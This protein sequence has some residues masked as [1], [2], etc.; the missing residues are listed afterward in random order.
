[1]FPRLIIDRE[2]LY[3]NACLIKN[4]CGKHGIEVVAVTKGYCALKGVIDVIVSAGI[5]KLADSRMLNIKRMR[6][7]GIKNHIMLIRI[8]MLSEISDV[9]RYVDS[10][11]VSEMVVLKAI[12]EECLR[13]KKEIDA[14]IMV[15]VGDLREGLMPKDVSGF[16]NE[17]K[18]LKGV[19]I[20]GIAT[21]VG[22]IGGIMPDKNNIALLIEAA[23]RAE[24]IL[25]RR[26]SVI[27]GGSTCTLKLI[28]DD[29]MPER[30]N[31][32]RIGEAILFGI[33]DVCGRD[34]PGTYKDVFTLEAEVVE[35]KRKPSKPLGEV[36]FDAFGEVPHFEDRG[37]RKRAILALGRQDVIIDSIKPRYAGMTIVGASS[38]HLILDV[39][40]YEGTIEVGDVI[41]FDV[42]YGGL[43]SAS[44]SPYVEKVIR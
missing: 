5:E 41:P 8:P 32:L 44:T 36:G 17:A 16:I 24:S 33:N 12:S 27:S 19:N 3:H 21:N 31:Q 1:M 11:L 18:D 23:D 25:G 9:V 20:A 34:I 42:T 4:L 13:Q 26:L 39:E 28:D 43:L 6:Y 22:C 29:E 40:D 37:I 15:D 35:V 2:K 38:D 10:V 7:Y 30:V 14:F